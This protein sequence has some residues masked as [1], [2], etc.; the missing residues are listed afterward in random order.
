MTSS[1][2]DP[3]TAARTSAPVSVAAVCSA[4]LCRSSLIRQ[5]VDGTFAFRPSTYDDMA[6]EPSSASPATIGQLLA[7][8]AL[9]GSFDA[10]EQDHR[11]SFSRSLPPRASGM[12]IASLGAG[13]LR[14][15]SGLSVYARRAAG[16][17][18]GVIL[19]IAAF[20]MVGLYCHHAVRDAADDRARDRIDHHERHARGHG[21]G[22]RWCFSGAAMNW[23]KAGA[24]ALA[25]VGWRRST[26]CAAMMAAEMHCCSARRWSARRCA[27][28]R[29]IPCFRASF[30]TGSPRL[31]QPSPP[32]WWRSRCSCRLPCCSIRV[33][34][35]SAVLTVSL[36][37]R[38]FFLGGGSRGA[39]AGAVVQRRAQGTRRADRRAMA[40][41]P[42]SSLALSYVLLGEPFPVD[43]SGRFRTG[44]CRA[45]DDDRRT[46][47]GRQKER[48]RAGL[49]SPFS[50]PASIAARGA[51]L[52]AFL[53]DIP[54]ALPRAASA[55]GPSA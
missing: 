31:R 40:V 9:F 15:V 43:A 34:S 21:G 10:A 41:M 35:I 42:L 20:G 8:M 54:A 51:V 49:I 19:A 16:R 36:S 38:C 50:A 46:R 1:A 5:G 2:I 13:P 39:G 29:A 32:R 14:V 3:V 22:G 18:S 52:L 26:C 25:L 44:L 4:C 33:P 24:L 45:G 53:D 7:G 48:A 47:A 27:W 30:P 6:S 12:V 55:F 37:G 28:K 23:R 17:T 11:G